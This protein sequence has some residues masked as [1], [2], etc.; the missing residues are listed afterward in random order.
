MTA[1]VPVLVD[2][3]VRR[4][5]GAP[6]VVSPNGDGVLDELTFNFELTRAASVRLDVAQSGKT[7]ASVYSAD[8]LPG[9]QSVGWN[10]AGMKDGRYVGLL[11]ATNDVGIVTHTAAFR[12]DTVA[13]RLRA[14]SFRAALSPSVRLRR[15]GSP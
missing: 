1:V 7:L 15:S 8:L 13:P 5:V 11:T 4:F 10:G 14:L 9:V 2:R 12:I 3:T 6:A